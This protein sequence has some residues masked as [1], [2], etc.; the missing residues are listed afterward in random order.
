MADEGQ[1][2]CVG[3]TVNTVITLTAPRLGKQV[4]ALVETYG[5]DLRVREGG[6]FADFHGNFLE[7]LTL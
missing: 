7:G 6:Q 5:F 3:F 4:L 1:A 2:L